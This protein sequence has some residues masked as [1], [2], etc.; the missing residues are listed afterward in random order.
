VVFTD[1]QPGS[2]SFE[3]PLIGGDRIDLDLQ[4]PGAP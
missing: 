3:I 1:T 2:R 4:V